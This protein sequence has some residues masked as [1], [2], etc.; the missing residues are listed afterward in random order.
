MNWENKKN[1]KEEKDFL[2]STFKPDDTKSSYEGNLINNNGLL[3][4]PNEKT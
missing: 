4:F 3:K 2:K 1:N